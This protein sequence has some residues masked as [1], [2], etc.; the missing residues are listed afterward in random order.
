MVV[1]TVNSLSRKQNYLLGK[2]NMFPAICVD[3]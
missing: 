1:N 2:Q 3:K